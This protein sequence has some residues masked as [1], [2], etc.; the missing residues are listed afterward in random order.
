MPGTLV[1]VLMNSIAAARES[2]GSCRS[3]AAST[4]TARS[5]SSSS[6]RSSSSGAS[7]GDGPAKMSARSR[8]PARYIRPARRVS[9]SLPLS[10]SRRSNNAPVRYFR[11]STHAIALRT[12]SS[13]TSPPMRS[14]IAAR[15]R[16]RCV[17]KR[18]N[19]LFALSRK[20]PHRQPSALARANLARQSRKNLRPPQIAHRSIGQPTPA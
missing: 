8:M 7:A 18:H 15:R 2:P 12:S 13:L 5:R 9:Q 1:S 16:P 11:R 3:F 17:G 10:R 19:L 4:A 20:P 14:R 6:C